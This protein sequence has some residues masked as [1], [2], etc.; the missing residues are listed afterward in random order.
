M[1]LGVMGWIGA[2]LTSRGVQ[3]VTQLKH[4]SRPIVKPNAASVVKPSE[5]Q[6]K[7]D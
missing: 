6:K 5:K 3:F 7:S 1:Y 4:L 2:A